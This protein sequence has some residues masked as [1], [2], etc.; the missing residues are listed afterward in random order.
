MSNYVQIVLNVSLE[1]K[2]A[3]Y[4]LARERGFK[5]A[6]DYLRHLIESDSEALSKPMKFEVDRGGNRKG[7][8]KGIVTPNDT[9]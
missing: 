6:S 4:A 9:P 8:K 7:K 3:V 1:E 2:E 5:I